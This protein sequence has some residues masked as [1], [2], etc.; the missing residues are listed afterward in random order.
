MTS[1]LCDVL[2]RFSMPFVNRGEPG[3]GFK[4]LN[5]NLFGRVLKIKGR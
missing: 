3:L 4:Y 5:P 1:A 2:T